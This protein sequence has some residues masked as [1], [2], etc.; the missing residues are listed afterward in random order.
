MKMPNPFNL[1]LTNIATQ[2][3][4]FAERARAVVDAKIME[5]TNTKV[6][7]SSINQLSVPANTTKQSTITADSDGDFQFTGITGSFILAGFPSTGVILVE[8]KEQASGYSLTQGYVPFHLLVNPGYLSATVFNQ[9]YMPTPFHETIIRSTVL[10][11]NF[12]NTDP[13]NTATINVMAEGR[14]VY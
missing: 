14:K 5:Q 6:I 8:I 2:A 11:F 1:D 12:Q 4:Q 9:R 3:R 7:F 10:Q 13:A